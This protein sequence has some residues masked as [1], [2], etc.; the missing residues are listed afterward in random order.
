METVMKMDK[1]LKFINRRLSDLCGLM[2]LII[3]VL[4]LVNVISREFGYAIDGLSNLSVLILISVVYLG[5]STTEE[6]NQHAAV[7]LLENKLKVRNRKT[8][9]IAIHIIKLIAIGIFTYAA[10]GN[11]FTS[12]ETG[13]AFTDVVYIPMW[14]SKLALLVGLIFFEIQIALNLLKTILNIE[15]DEE[16][17]GDLTANL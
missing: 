2:L 5:L 4:L 14:P 17:T 9:M 13:E 3:M 1:I 7:E 8:L 16:K 6:A 10:V 12:V 11:F 15:N